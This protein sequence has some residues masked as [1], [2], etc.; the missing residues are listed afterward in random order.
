MRYLFFTVNNYFSSNSR[1]AFPGRIFLQ[2]RLFMIDKGHAAGG[3][4]G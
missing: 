3:A 2:S 1:L 4:V